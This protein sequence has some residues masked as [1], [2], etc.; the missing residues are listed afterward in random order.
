MDAL[1]CRDGEA[2]HQRS[3][4]GAVNVVDVCHVQN[5]PGLVRQRGLELIPELNALL[6]QS[7]AAGE[8]KYSDWAYLLLR[9]LK[10]H[11]TASLLIGD[12]GS[13]S[14]IN[15]RTFGLEVTNRRSLELRTGHEVT[16]TGADH[17]APPRDEPLRTDR[18]ELS[19]ELARRSRRDR[20]ESRGISS[21]WCV[22]P[23]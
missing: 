17:F 7:N 16:A 21:S 19:R 20:S 23:V 9:D 2:S 8:L 13:K 10:R 14:R 5:Q 12:C 15:N 18:A 3:Q 11:E 22:V 6:A 1:V 4:A